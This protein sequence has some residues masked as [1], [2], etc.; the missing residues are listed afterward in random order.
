MNKNAYIVSGIVVAA[1]IL[2]GMVF[3]GQ[4]KE[5]ASEVATVS[6]QPTASSVATEAAVVANEA[7]IFYTDSGF[8]P[9]S[10]KVKS[11][12][13]VTFT[14][15]SGQKMWVASN[16]HPLHADLPGFDELTAVDRGGTYTYAFVKVGAW[17]YHNHVIP[18][19]T[20]VVVVE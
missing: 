2:V 18:G 17:V 19:E 13:M 11:K 6:A 9:G 8:T 14:N 1:L 7:Q 16:V 5:P 3:F 12:T 15:S 10:L 20:G 4:K